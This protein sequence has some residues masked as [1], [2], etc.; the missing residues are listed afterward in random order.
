MDYKIQIF[1]AIIVLIFFIIIVNLLRTKKLNLKYTL[2]WLFATIILLIVSLLPEIMYI[3]SDIV[4]IKT[5]INIA[6]ILAGI[7][8]VLILISI[9]SIVSELN[10]KLRRLVQEVA[11]LKKQINELKANQNNEGE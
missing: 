7:F 4:G 1:F 11:L 2:L 10:L 5:P 9:T 8:I 6:L 3:I